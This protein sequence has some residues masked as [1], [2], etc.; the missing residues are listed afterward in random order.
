[1]DDD[2]LREDYLKWRGARQDE[3]LPPQPT[4]APQRATPQ[5]AYRE[6]RDQQK[7][8]AA[9]QADV[10]LSQAPPGNVMIDAIRQSE[11]AKAAGEDIPAHLLTDPKSALVQAIDQQSRRAQLASS[12][13]LAGWITA[14]P[15]NAALAQAELE[16]LSGLEA[17]VSA[18]GRSSDRFVTGLWTRRQTQVAENNLQGL[19]ERRADDDRSFGGIV[20]DIIEQQDTADLDL[21]PG[22]AVAKTYS[23]AIGRFVASRLDFTE[24]AEHDEFEAEL[25]DE[26]DAAIERET[27]NTNR[28]GKTY[29]TT[30]GIARTRRLV[31]TASEQEG[32]GA[33]LSALGEVIA[34]DPGAFTAFAADV[35]VDSVPSIA[36][37]VVTT[38]VTRRP[39]AGAAVMGAGA[40][41]QGEVSS[42]D[43]FVRESGYDL[44]DPTQR[45][46]FVNDP[47]LRAQ[48]RDRSFTYGLVIGLVDAASGGI[49][50]KTLAQSPA[51]NMILQG[52]VQAVMGSGGEALASLASGQELNAVELALEGLIELASTPA[53]VIGVGGSYLKE[54]RRTEQDRQ[55]FQSLGESA[56]S[57][58]LRK[59]VPAKYR[60]AVETLTKDGPLESVY[61]DAQQLDELFQSDA[62]GVSAEEFATSIPGV[63]REVYQQALESGGVI[64]IPTSSYAADVVGTRFDPVLRDYLRTAP[65]RRSAAESRA[66]LKQVQEEVTRGTTAAQAAQETATETDRVLEDARVELVSALRQAGRTTSVAE[67][68]AE[69]TVA[70]ARTTAQRLGITTSEFLERYP[71]PTIQGVTETAGVERVS[72]VTPEVLERARTTEDI[73]EA[74]DR[75]VIELVREAAEAADIDLATAEPLEIERAVYTTFGPAVG[76]ALLNQSQRPV[77]TGDEALERALTAAPRGEATPPGGEVTYDIA[78]IEARAAELEG[79]ERLPGAPDVEGASGPDPYL[80]AVAEAYAATEGIRLQRQSEFATVDA[81]RATRI[82]DAYEK[83]KHNPVDLGVKTAYEN[84]I[85]E[86]RAQYDALVAA[87]YEFWFFDPARDPYNG[88]PWNAMRDLRAN[89]AMGVY[90]TEAGYGTDGGD[91]SDN[92]LLV[93]TGLVWSYGEK[94][95]GDLRP[96]TANDL[97]RAVHDAFGHGLEGSGFRAR[98]EENAWQAHVRMFGSWARQAMTTETR[99]QNSWLNY[100]PHGEKNRTARVE[101]T[102]FAEQKAGLLPDWAH[103]EGIV[104]DEVVDLE[105]D[106]D[107]MVTLTHWSD[108]PRDVIDPAFA[109][110]GPVYGAERRKGGIKKVFFGMG[111]GGLHGYRKEAFGNYRHVARVPAT[112]LYNLTT[113][114][115]GLIASIPDEANWGGRLNWVEAEIQRRGYKGYA[116]TEG[117]HGMSA[118]LFEKVTPERVQDDSTI[119]FFQSGANPDFFSA[120]TREVANA[121]QKTATGR[122]WAAIIPKL[123]GIKKAEIEWSG[124][125]PFLA[126]QEGQI[127]REVVADFLRNNEVEIEPVVLGGDGVAQAFEVTLDSPYGDP[128]D[129][130]EDYI[131]ETAT[132]VYL[133]DLIEDHLEM[134]ANSDDYEGDTFEEDDISQGDMADLEE[135]ADTAARENHEPEYRYTYTV[136]LPD[137]STVSEDVYADPY[138]EYRWDG[139]EYGNLEDAQE[140]IAQHYR[141]ENYIL[142]EDTGPKWEEYTEAG[143]EEY[144]EVLLTVPGLEDRGP[145]ADRRVSEYVNDSHF[146]T[147][148]I[149][150]YARLNYRKAADGS[151]VM[152]VE[153]VQSD[154]GSEWREAGGFDK[155]DVERKRYTP[156]TPF[157][158][159]AYYAL[160]MK[161]L[162]KVA[163]EEGADKLAW[164]PAYMQ[165]RRWSGAV[166]NVVR[167]IDWGVKDQYSWVAED[168]SIGP[169]REVIVNGVNGEDAFLVDD[170]GVIREKSRSGGPIPEGDVVGKKL[171]DLIG[172]TMAQRVMT[173][174]GGGSITGQNIVVGG[175]GYKIA[176][177]QQIKKF[178][179]KFAKKYGSRV[180][181]DTTMPD[182]A[183][184]DRG[185]SLTQTVSAFGFQNFIARAKESG[186]RSEAFWAENEVTAEKHRQQR[187]EKSTDNLERLR[188]RLAKDQ[189]DLREARAQGLDETTSANVRSILAGTKADTEAVAMENERLERLRDPENFAYI[190]YEAAR[191]GGHLTDNQVIDILPEDVR[192]KGDAVWSVDITD[193]LRSAASEAQPLFQRRPDGARGSILLPTEPGRAPAISLFEKADLSTV[194]HE[195]GHYYLHVL[196]DINAQGNVPDGVAADWATIKKWWGS[197][198][199]GVAKDGGVSQDNVRAYLKDGTTGDRDID[200]KVNVGLQE[201]WARAYEKYLLEGRAPSQSLRAAFESFSAWLVSIYKRARNLD[202]NVSDEM[203]GV[204]DRLLATD[205][206]IAAATQENE[207]AQLVASSAAELGIDDVEYRKLVALAG[208]AQDEARERLQEQIMAP[209]RR[210]MTAEFK[211]EREQVEAEIRATV[212]AKPANRVR[213]WLG[214]SRWLGDGDAPVELGDLQLDTALL[215]EEHGQEMA[216]ALPRGRRQM[217]KKGTGVSA[218]DLAGWFGYTSGGAMLEDV[219]TTPK[220]EAEI[221][222][223]TDAEMRKRHGDILSDGTVGAAAVDALHGDKRGQLLEAELRALRRAL[224]K[225]V[226]SVED[227][228]RAVN[229]DRRESAADR[230]AALREASNFVSR[231]QAS[232]I[233]RKIIRQ[234]PIRKAVQSATYLAAE[235]KAGSAAMTAVARGDMAAAFKAKREQLLNHQMY[236]ESRKANELLGKVENKVA[237]LKSKGTR[238]NLAG[239]YLGAIDDILT[240][241][242]FRKSVTQ[243]QARSRQGLR[244]YVEMMKAEGRENEL[245]IPAHVLDEARRRPYKTLAVNELE[246]VYDS[247]RNIEHTA[248]MK[249]KLRDAQAERDMTATVEGITA[250]MN[251]NLEDKAPNRVQTSKEKRGRGV[252]EFANLLLNADTLLRKLGG[253]TRGASYEAMKA[254]LD[255][256]ADV[257]ATMRADASDAFEKLYSVYTKKERRAMGVRKRHEDLKGDFTKWDLLSIAMNMGNADNMARL[258]DKDSGGGFT[259]AQLDYV[260]GQLDKRDWDFVQASLDNINS[261][262]PLIVAREKRLTGVAPKKVN[263][264]EIETPYGN[265]PG[266]YYPIKYRSDVSG[267]VAAEEVQSIQE[268]MMAGRFGKAQTRNG[269]LEERAQGSGGRVLQIGIEVMHQHIG[270]VIHDLSFSEPVANTWRL[271]QDPR[272]RSAF[273]AKGLLKDHQTL[274]LWVK[275]A[276][277]GQLAAGGVWGRL[278]L[279]AK[280][281][282]TLSKLAFNMSTVAVQ[283]TGIAQSVVVVGSKNMALGY[284]DYFSNPWRT[285]AEVV[286]MS[287]VM[288]DRETTF[289]RDINDLLNDVSKDGPTGSAY[290]KMQEILAKWGLYTMQKVQFYG[291]DVPT[292]YGGYRQGL[293]LY[294]NDEAKA[295]VHADRMVERAQ[296]SSVFHNRSAFERGTLDEGTRQNAFI[297]LFT[298]LGSYMFA[299]GN[300][301]YEVAGR[302][303]RDIDG[304]NAKSFAAA[305]HGASDMALLFT[306]E[307]IAYNLIKGTLPGMG[308]DGEDEESWAAFLAKQTALSM[309]STVPGIRD[310]GSGLSGFDAGAYA[311]ILATFARPVEQVGQGELDMPLFKSISN[312]AGVVTGLPTGQLN[313]V[314]DAWYR[315]D[316]G[317]DVSPVEFIM[318]RR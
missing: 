72:R 125:M 40:L 165:A 31:A 306:I 91:V 195:T 240:S 251:A 225:P 54:R 181:V 292:W 50:G 296:A 45:A 171:S 290:G 173:E 35:F 285:S 257:S 206:E 221:K 220:A 119:E 216:D 256:A 3:N 96:V 158:G 184:G 313:R 179:E 267:M 284:S 141:D 39:A 139:N 264:T 185:G 37:G 309:M 297:R 197:N 6:Y 307:A 114:P 80:T 283:L 302:T 97:F 133:P 183:R 21:N 20:D 66:Y 87:G 65:E 170:E 51:G 27:A 123:P 128:V 259:R 228:Q 63:T 160:M 79:L 281:G 275:D 49:A 7:K 93:D 246:G 270:Q 178:V 131:S 177:D 182:F 81:E 305:L 274:E 155:N 293:D 98:G 86:T 25:T 303:K 266:G 236:V 180:T 62:E 229:R 286:A 146:D 311:S 226:N 68:E 121:K 214:N 193:K 137:G 176:Y 94:G 278:A 208:E 61:V 17:T 74:P 90:P 299:K 151:K 295:R 24:G 203:R 138:G 268:T 217:H 58:E 127:P 108:A 148:N 254:P 252:R 88:N 26:L 223:R 277:T 156:A 117:P 32:M 194:L 212:Q 294:G 271:L 210:A 248:R 149:V 29:G 234:L 92:P 215:I 48:I 232:E 107:G 150:V 205:E 260:K 84:L 207:F 18:F 279:R 105:V 298:A 8:R 174:D 77:V 89:R 250:E 230:R 100:G 12:S 2:A 249:Q 265:Y 237:R 166:Q 163:A 134:M 75:G 222:A 106:A 273:E 200:R 112:D 261:Y 43:K 211:A 187:T 104:K 272:I 154:L 255:A 143:G 41:T 16:N 233:A 243:R 314:A 122:D 186:L 11:R 291:V 15:M 5:D 70:V 44:T 167:N 110:S 192:P 280:N 57:S 172:G 245:A 168:G 199:A 289:N 253:F 59:N 317:E 300:I 42:Y 218:D 276:A 287:T 67:A 191:T 71:L 34:A 9:A 301:A 113:D 263:A 224:R 147:P 310:L 201:Q 126:A 142:G 135:Q 159:E 95:S 73:S 315:L 4:V 227:T 209:I 231:K 269:H 22:F 136:D 118:A 14:D 140:A 169:A 189:E 241:Y 316:R 55:F 19:N 130:D 204:F 198:I 103:K 28:I 190:R 196:Q 76:P 244:D 115:D 47:E 288:R 13:R 36:A 52:L 60:E 238:K 83:M 247:L 101:D 33:Q 10:V 46:A 102:V 1:M 78:A 56:E 120:L 239:E 85:V 161:K 152:F 144:R 304:F 109:G 219:V 69:Q 116:V 175:D 145:N 162:L 53:D 82:A 308:D 164:T 202:V 235:R 99:G 157:E 318:G 23:R 312:A 64:E 124:V 129:P 262:W 38:A 213:E 132:E 258:M 111:L 153:E 30:A 242:D 282:F 188:A